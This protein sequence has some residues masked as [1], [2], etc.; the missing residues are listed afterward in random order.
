[1]C[2][3]PEHF[4]GVFTTRRCTNPHLPYLT[5]PLLFHYIFALTISSSEL[6][7]VSTSRIV[8]HSSSAS[9]IIAGAQLQHDTRSEQDHCRSTTTTRHTQRAGSQLQHDT[10]SEQDHCRSTTTT[11]HT[12]RAGSLQEHNYNTTHAASRITT[13]TRHTQRAGSQL[14]HDTCSEQD[15]CRSTTTTRHKQRAGSLQEHNYNTTQYPITT[16]SLLC[17]QNC[18]NSACQARSHSLQDDLSTKSCQVQHISTSVH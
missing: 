6:T 14:Q 11:R 8:S 4:R 15:H 2:A 5:F 9:R 18:C 10:R 16:V 12:Q 13:T 17:I 1:M 7:E 3:I